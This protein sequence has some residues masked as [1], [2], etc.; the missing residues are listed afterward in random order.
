M[1]ETQPVRHA[2]VNSGDLRL[3]RLEFGGAGRP[4]VLVHGVTGHA[5]LWHDVAA[6][7]TSLRRVVSVDMRG[8]GDSQW[9]VD[10]A[11]G[12]DDHALDLEAVVNDL[13]EAPVDLAGL[14]WGALVA[15]AF[16]SRHPDLVGRLAM[17]DVEPSF[18]QGETDVFPRPREFADHA[19]AA[20]WVRETNPNAPDGIVEVVATMGT[21]PGPN[22]TLVPKHDPLFFERWPF[23]SDD[24]WE[25]LRTLSVPLLVVRADQTWVRA[26]VAERMAGEAPDGRLVQLSDSTHLIPVEQPTEL[27]RALGTFFAEESDRKG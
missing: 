25:E 5:S 7:L 9:S 3:H 2:F 8:H 11:Y 10:S 15:L 1:T 24:R 20:A 19:A 17:V 16:A 12:T 18:E 6:G 23:R 4:L 14:S 22:G 21:R 26:E 27:G 13:G